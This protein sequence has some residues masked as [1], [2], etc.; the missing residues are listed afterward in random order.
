MD[1][2]I[3]KLTL[4]LPKS[5]NHI[6]G[7]NKFGS[8]YLKKEGKDYKRKMIKLIQNEVK[9]QKWDKPENTFIYL[10]EIVYMNKKGRDADN[11]K[12]LTQDC[13]TESRIVWEDDCFC[14]PRTQRILIDKNNPRLEIILSK[15]PYIG[16]FKDETEYSNF[17]NTYCNECTRGNKLGKKGGCSIYKKALENRVQ[18]ELTIMKCGEKKCLE[19]NQK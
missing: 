6:Y 9:K 15:A 12:K 14:L 4:D 3:L 19:F 17:V 16:I 11:L 7:R 5:V 18:D 13:I 8:T 2:Q 1:N 10:D